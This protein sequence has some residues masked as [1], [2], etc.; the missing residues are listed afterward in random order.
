MD[1]PEAGAS[2]VYW[3]GFYSEGAMTGRPCS[4]EETAI[5]SVAARRDG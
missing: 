3:R 2:Y 5:S 1:S 4:E